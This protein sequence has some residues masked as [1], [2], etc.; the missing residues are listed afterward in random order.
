[1]T[2]LED[3]LNLVLV[4]SVSRNE[5]AL[6]DIIERRLRLNP[7]LVVERIGDNVVA[8]TQAGHA[9]RL[10]VAGHIDTVPG[11]VVNA[12]IAG[13]VLYGVGACDMKASLAVMLDVAATPIDR[14]VDVTWVFYARE[15]I[16]RAESGLLEIAQHDPSLL[17]ADAAV[18]AEPTDG[19]VEAGCQGTLRLVLTIHGVRAHVARAFTGR[20]AIH[21]LGPVLLRVAEYEPRSVSIDGCTFT[22]Q[23]QVVMVDGGI[24][25]NVVPDQ[26]RVTINH[27]VAPDRDLEAAVSWLRAFLG[28]TIEEADDVAVEDWAPPAM[29]QL[30]N[31]LLA[32]LLQQTGR[33][34]RAKVGWTD[35]ATLQETGT[36]ATNFGAGDPL[37]AHRADECVTQS[38]VS[39]FSSVLKQWLS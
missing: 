4:D 3:V 12:R 25:A 34:P 17:R 11:D 26:V 20:N 28:E 9:T 18:V 24:A 33:P 14:S 7:S 8:R 29:P 19:F 30:D 5:A 16:A 38:Q 13:D 31:P 37:L 6:C 23:L 32:R 21:R 15:E 10:L 35:V 22:E 27:R 36:P 1:M 2:S 39:N